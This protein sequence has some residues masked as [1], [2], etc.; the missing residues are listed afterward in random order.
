MKT[1]STHV[2]NDSKINIIHQNGKHLTES[3]IG[4]TIILH[5]QDK[6]PVC[7]EVDG[8]TEDHYAE[9]GLVITD[10][11]LEEYDGVFELPKEVIKVLEMRGIDCSYAKWQDEFEL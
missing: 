2:F 5:E 7:A 11:I 4:I 8:G 9:I 10:N 3:T 1:S 6:V